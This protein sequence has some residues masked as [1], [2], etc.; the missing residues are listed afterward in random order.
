MVLSLKKILFLFFL[1]I[2]IRQVQVEQGNV[3]AGA[4]RLGQGLLGAGGGGNA[5]A[6]AGEVANKIL[7]Q[8]V[9]VIDDQQP[10]RGAR[11]C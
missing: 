1:S 4:G 5:Q 11:W 3:V 7:A 8:V 2:S 9:I 10:S 6:G